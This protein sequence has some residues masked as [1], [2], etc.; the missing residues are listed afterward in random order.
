MDRDATAVGAARSVRAARIAPGARG[1]I[2]SSPGWSRD[3]TD[4]LFASATSER[5][6]PNLRAT[7]RSVSF[8][9]VVYHLSAVKSAGDASASLADSLSAVPTGTLTS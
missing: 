7:L 6:T 8:F 3:L 2:S 5:D 9:F 1:M 4:R